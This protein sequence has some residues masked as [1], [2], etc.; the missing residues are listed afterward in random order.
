M[1]NLANMLGLDA[2]GQPE[3]TETS[4]PMVQNGSKQGHTPNVKNETPS[5]SA[6]P[7]NRQLSMNRQASATD[8]KPSVAKTN[9][10]KD[11]S[12][13]LQSMQNEAKAPAQQEQAQTDLWG[14]T[15]INPHDLLQTLKPLETGAGGAISDMEAYRSITSNNTP[16]SSKDG[17]S[18]PNSDISDGVG[19]DIN[20]DISTM[21]DDNWRPFGGSDMDALF[22]M[23][24]F[25]VSGG[26]DLTMADDE[27]RQKWGSWDDMVDQSAFDKPFEFDTSLYSM[28]AD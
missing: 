24:G 15:T 6:T 14:N 21:F 10:A 18:E 17:I 19:L 22:D 27:P 28:K 25:N 13:K 3:Q 23:D 8:G 26:E 1:E 16:E 5:A 7:M 11:A 12:V 4:T 20:I 2:S 9:L